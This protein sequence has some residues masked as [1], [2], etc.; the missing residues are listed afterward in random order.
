VID[1]VASKSAP[2][3]NIV[4]GGQSLQEMMAQTGAQAAADPAEQLG[5][6]A[7][8]HERGVLTDEEFAAQKAKVLGTS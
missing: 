2:G 3:A 1:T 6:L 8:L 7:D 4:I 5:K